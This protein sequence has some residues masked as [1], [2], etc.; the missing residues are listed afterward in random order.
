MR[1]Q[2]KSLVAVAI[3]SVLTAAF[4]TAASADYVLKYKRHVDEY[5][6]NGKKVPATDAAPVTTLAKDK[7][8]IDQNADTA[9]II[10]LDKNMVYYLNNVKKQYSE[11]SLD[12][13]N[14]ALDTSMAAKDKP[15]G[16]D[17]EMPAIMAGM[18]KMIKMEATVTPGTE[19][20]K[21]GKWDCSHYTMAMTIMMSTT[22]SDIWSTGDIKIDPEF[23]AK[24]LSAPMF[25]MQGSEKLIAEMKKI[26]GVPVLMT[27]TSQV[28]KAEIHSSEELTDVSETAA[29][30][31]LFE[32]PKGYKKVK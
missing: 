18:M 10:R 8:R 30:P 21:I 7:C 11:V 24:F 13:I 28:M 12:A 5:T 31:D 3:V 19:Q 29:S 14:K 27:S 25:R 20:K 32:I 22:N 2:A 15:S 17:K 26:K 16:K 6:M 1:I 23:Y 4:F 9:I